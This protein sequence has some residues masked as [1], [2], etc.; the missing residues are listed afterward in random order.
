MT[1][2]TNRRPELK[3]SG[4]YLKTAIIMANESSYDWNGN[5]GCG[6]SGRFF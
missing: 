4:F 2:S 1:L 6:P 5:E 3:R